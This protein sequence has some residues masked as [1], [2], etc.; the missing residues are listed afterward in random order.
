MGKMK[1]K[2]LDS[3]SK[4]YDKGYACGYYD[5]IAE[6]SWECGDCK[7][8]YDISVKYCPNTYLDQAI[9]NL[10]KEGIGHE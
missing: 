7:N 4:G 2:L 5:A 10:E 3:H 8:T 9:L 1:E 6:M